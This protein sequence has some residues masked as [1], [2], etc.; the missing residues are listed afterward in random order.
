M[1]SFLLWRESKILAPLLVGVGP[2]TSVPFRSQ[3]TPWEPKAKATKFPMEFLADRKF[4][5]VVEGLGPLE[6]RAVKLLA[7]RKYREELIEEL[8]RTNTTIKRYSQD[9][10]LMT[11]MGALDKAQKKRL[12]EKAGSK[13]N[14][15]SE[16]EVPTK[17]QRTDDEMSEDSKSE[18]EDAI[19][20]M[21][22]GDGPAKRPASPV[23]GK[24]RRLAD[25]KKKD[26]SLAFSET[27]K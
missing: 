6:Q 2:S 9:S 22:D 19:V 20:P 7:A 14:S 11:V 26:S 21:K 16:D 8:K 10:Q 25:Q 3:V 27:R 15:D 1:C 17:K 24:A 23:R 12:E 4:T 13:R 18:D 5:D